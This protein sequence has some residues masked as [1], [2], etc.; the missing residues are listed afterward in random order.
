MER[1]GRTQRDVARVLRIDP[2]SVS[3]LLQGKRR[4]KAEEAETLKRFFGADRA[5]VADLPSTTSKLDDLRLSTI[6]EID[7]RG[8]LGSGGTAQELIDPSSGPIDAPR[9]EWTLPTD[10]L[11]EVGIR[12]NHTKI[13]E[14]RG[15][16]MLPTLQSGDRI[17]VDLSDRNPTPPGIFCIWDGFGV[18][19]KHLE[20][21]LGTDPPA[22]RV[23][24]ANDQYNDETMVAD[25][26]GIIGRAV[27]MARRL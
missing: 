10:Y 2:S 7:V 14:V 15:D 3:R 26:I 22:I 11:L 4:L 23:S 13:I 18:A 20:R 17:A 1:T 24:S 27:W 25:E 6:Q 16:S 9:A 12:P 8:G 21:L 19:V 5:P